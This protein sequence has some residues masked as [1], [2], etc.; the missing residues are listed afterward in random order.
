M[1]LVPYVKEMIKLWQRTL[2]EI[3]AIRLATPG[4]PLV[5][6]ADPARLQQALTNI[7]INARDAMAGGGEL[8]VSLQEMTVA[9]EDAA[10]LP[11]ITPGQWVAIA[12]ADTG[13]GI[14]P[15]V[16]PR[17]FDPFFTT[18]PPGQ[19]TGL[20]LAQVYGIVRQLGGQIQVESLVGQGT[21]FTLYLPML[22]RPY[23]AETIT[24]LAPPRGAGETIL[25]VEDE[26]AL[27]TA[28]LEMLSTLGY[29]VLTAE[30]GR[31]ARELYEAYHDRIAL[32]ISDL[33]MPDMSGL[34][35]HALLQKEP[36]NGRP[37]RLLLVT[38]YPLKDSDKRI[39]EHG[40]V[41]WIQKPF[42]MDTL[43][44]RVAL[45]LGNPHQTAK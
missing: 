28:M 21:R 12:I 3:V 33:V 18:K 24:V 10:P 2:P 4:D 26:K 22:D 29:Q 6:S 15:D 36:L 19:G 23:T 43:A 7:A 45:A 27:R 41:D 42:T 31:R 17:I 44:R 39:I 9:D 32:L 40:L 34:E 13:V 16:L 1:D 37:L 20:G 14:P 5:V 38:G 30:S 35:L 8:T 11:G 25:L